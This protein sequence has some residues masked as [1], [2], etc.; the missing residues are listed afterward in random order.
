MRPTIALDTVQRD[1][2]WHWYGRAADTGKLI[3]WDATPHVTHLDARQAC[4]DFHD[5]L[6]RE[7]GTTPYEGAFS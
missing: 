5:R 3:L 2:A 1:G 7:Q 4:I 6:Q